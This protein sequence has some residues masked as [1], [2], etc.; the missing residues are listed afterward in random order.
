[1]NKLERNDSV[2]CTTHEDRLNLINL[3]CDNGLRIAQTT[4]NNRALPTT[5]ETY[6]Y[7]RWDGCNVNGYKTNRYYL[8]VMPLD[9]FLEKAGLQKLIQPIKQMLQ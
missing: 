9:E 1:M 4:W 6:P 5:S 3:L 2:Y 7:V 8:N